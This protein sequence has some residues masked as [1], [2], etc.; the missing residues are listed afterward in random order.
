M[1]EDLD[2]LHG[3]FVRP[4]L[5]TFTGLGALGL[6]VVAQRVEPGQAS[7]VC[8]VAD[9]GRLVLS[10]WLSGGWRGTRSSGGWFMSRSGG[11][12]RRCWCPCAATGVAV[13]AT[14]GVRT[15][16]GRLSR[17]RSYPGRRCGGHWLRLWCST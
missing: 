2:M 16:A 13:V 8:R 14:C 6:E 17:V 11:G 9:T 7:L 15:R 4:D 1:R 10:V 12:R 5:T 3:T